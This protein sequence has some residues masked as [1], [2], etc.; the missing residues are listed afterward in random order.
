VAGLRGIYHREPNMHISEGV[1][2]APVLICGAAVA[3]AGT[4]IGLKKMDYDRLPQVAILSASFFVGSL[5]HVP[6]GPTSV[7][8]VLN[9]LLGIFLGWVSFPA[10][11]VG[12][13]LQ[14]LLFQFGGLTAIGVNAVTMAGPAILCY[15]LFKTGARSDVRSMSI[16]FSFL[17]GFCGILFG[18]LILALALIFTGEAFFAVAKLVVAAHLPVMVIEGLITAF[19]VQF[20]KRVKPEMLEVVY[21][22]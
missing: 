16:V 11:L 8:L 21:A 10:I 7:H 20:L 18:S 6:I 13:L 14:A 22:R 3:A 2:S 1:L 5:V 4:G 9:G 19:C 15:A 12:L 17:C